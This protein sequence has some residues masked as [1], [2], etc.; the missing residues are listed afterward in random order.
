[1]F[2][3][4]GDIILRFF[5][6]LGALILAI[7]KIPQKLSNINRDR[8]KEKIDTENIKENVSKVKENL[9]ID[10]KTSKINSKEIPSLKETTH[11]KRNNTPN[12][13]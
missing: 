11:P 3:K 9:G 4:L 12:L 5:S 7:P 10:E 1:M 6:L 8:V 13:S 2:N